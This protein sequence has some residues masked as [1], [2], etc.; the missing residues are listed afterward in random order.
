M[1]IIIGVVLFL[2]FLGVLM[3]LF[4]KG[5]SSTTLRPYIGLLLIAGLI[6]GMGLVLGFMFKEA[7]YYFLIAAKGVAVLAGAAM[8]LQLIGVVAK[9]WF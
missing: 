7:E 4:E 1:A 9:R 5:K 3:N 8:C 2:I 6:A